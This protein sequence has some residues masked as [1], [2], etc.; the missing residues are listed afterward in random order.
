MQMRQTPC[1]TRG[2]DAPGERGDDGE[3]ECGDEHEG[4]IPIEAGP[5]DLGDSDDGPLP[6]FLPG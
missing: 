5:L 2:G 1:V 3:V 4:R 6:L